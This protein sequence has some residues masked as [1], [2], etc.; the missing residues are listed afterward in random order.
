M[1]YITSL[2]IL[3][4]PVTAMAASMIET[5]DGQGHHSRIYIDGDRARVEMPED[6]GYMVMDVKN[7]SMKAVIP[8]QRT[9]M[10]MSD[11]LKSHG[12]TAAGSKHVNSS[13]KLK[14]SGPKIAG[15]ATQQ[16]DIYANGQYC[17]S[18]YVSA[19]AFNDLD[20]KK[21]AHAM[22]AM[23]QQIQEKM[24]GMGLDQL[25]S[26]CE[27]AEFQLSDKLQ[28]MGFPLRFID[29]N[30]KLLSEVTSISRNAK[31]PANAFAIPADYRVMNADKMMQDAVKQ[32]PNMQE[33]MK[34]MPPEAMEMMRKNME[35]MNQQQ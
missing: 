21:F 24:S 8:K 5:R 14:G 26:A 17:G 2:L 35:K 23:D 18:S 13:S 15:Y 9:V 10:D 22:Q 7:N 20:M 6:E 16:Y 29:H 28:A 32:M 4:L 3:A 19:Q 27:Q 25:T 31:L 11:M 30:K 33:L 12:N 34:N 1:R